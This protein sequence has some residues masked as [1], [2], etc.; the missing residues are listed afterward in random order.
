[1]RCNSLTSH[2]RHPRSRP[3]HFQG[4]ADCLKL[5]L[6][7]ATLALHPACGFL[8][9]GSLSLNNSKPGG[10]NFDSAQLLE[11]DS[12][13]R[14][15]ISG[16]VSGG[17]VH[18]YDLGALAAGDRVVVTADGGA[19][20]A[21]DPIAAL[22]NADGEL[23]VIND[24]LDLP[25][26]RLE[27]FI[28]E[29]VRSA[30]PKYYLAVAKSPGTSNDGA[31]SGSVR[32]ER[33]GAV[34]QP[35]PQVLVL[36][37][38]GGAIDIPNVGP[39]NLPPFNGADIDGAYAGQTARIRGGIV[40]TVVD[41]YGDFGLIIITDQDP[42][43]PGCQVTT[44]HFGSFSRTVFGIAQG[45]DIGNV[46]RCDDG[47][48]YT[49]RFDD[50]FAV[51]PSVDGIA[52]AIGNVASH[53]AGHL[54]GLNHVADVTDLMDSTGTASTLLADQSFKTAPLDNSIFPIGRQNGLWLLN[55]VIPR[56]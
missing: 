7:V 33:D 56:P 52:V 12:D 8:F 27:S 26:G 28:D 6:I 20:R 5:G 2:F 38:A 32:V 40:Q 48:V 46:D 47:I 24:D 15:S 50:P 19:G 53:E 4:S 16:R 13:G 29:R 11:F 18:V 39:F 22:F 51:Q 44:I 23:F 25:S 31:Y 35:P 3:R 55:M 37:F 10:N 17:Q 21:L 1:M 49:D 41:N 54:F 34:P 45:V 9:P 43:P 42:I 36:N 30:S 14:A